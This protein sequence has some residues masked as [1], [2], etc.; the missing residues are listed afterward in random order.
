MI[1]GGLRARLILDSVRFAV[2]STLQQGGWFDPTIHDTPPG[3]RRHEPFR[4]IP[5]PSDWAEDIRP[6]AIAVTPEDIA[7][8]PAGFGGEVQDANEIYVDL[9]AQDD[10]LGW[11]VTFDIRDSLL[12]KVHGGAGP[13]IDVYD[14]RQPTP[15]PF[16]TVDIDLVEVDRSQGE[17]RSW[18]RHWFMMHLVLLDDY[19]DEPP[20]EPALRS[21]VRGEGQPTWTSAARTAW[22]RIQEVE[23][24]VL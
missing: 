17:A 8:E 23:R 7:D 15:A 22:E 11:Q 16:T 21:S 9:F 14:F 5:R 18:Q 2:I 4:Y 13:Q 10:S 19:D 3:T 24:P 20:A 6:N 12:G 1:R